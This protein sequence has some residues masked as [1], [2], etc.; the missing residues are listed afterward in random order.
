MGVKKS[1]SGPKVPMSEEQSLLAAIKSFDQVA[2]AGPD[3]RA[4]AAR[5]RWNQQDAEYLTAAM[6]SPGG[7]MYGPAMFQFFA[8]GVL[9][10]EKL[11]VRILG[12]NT[13]EKVRAC[14]IDGTKH[15]YIVPTGSDDQNGIKVTRYSDQSWINLVKLL[16]PAGI[17]VK[18]G[19]RERYDLTLVED[20]PVG[21]ALFLNLAQMQERRR[22]RKS[23]GKNA[24]KSARKSAPKGQQAEPT[25]Q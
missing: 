25:E 8:S 17:R 19:Y 10:L 18:S 9:L 20:T 7:W 13:V 6:N 15:V 2:A 24:K 4:E 3:Q 21:P 22:V 11:G 5:L 16:A 12:T 1:G 14:L 23:T